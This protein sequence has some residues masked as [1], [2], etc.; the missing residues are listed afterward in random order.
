MPFELTN[1]I[2]RTAPAIRIN[3][4]TINFDDRK[5]TVSYVLVYEDGREEVKPF[6]SF[7][8]WTED[9]DEGVVQHPDFTD[10]YAD[11]STHEY[12]YT[13]IAEKEGLTGTFDLDGE[14]Q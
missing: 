10:F 2:Q 11:Y 7:E 14:P 1:P 13:K 5:A 9:T 3:R 12:L 8:D 4:I 6:I